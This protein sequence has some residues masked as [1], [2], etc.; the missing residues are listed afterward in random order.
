MESEAKVTATKTDKVGHTWRKAVDVTIKATL[1]GGNGLPRAQPRRGSRLHFTKDGDFLAFE[2]VVEDTLRTRRMRLCDRCLMPNHWHFVVW[3]Q[4][5]GDLSA[6]MQQVTETHVKRW[7]EHRH[8]IGYGHLYQG[9]TSVSQWKLKTR[10][11]MSLATW[12]GTP[13]VQTSW[14]ERN[15]GDGQVCAVWSME[16]QRF[17][18]SRRGRF[19]ALPIGCNLADP[20][21]LQVLKKCRVSGRRHFCHPTSFQGRGCENGRSTEDPASGS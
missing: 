19:L 5:D 10:S 16:A 20:T 11:I 12:R 3:P 2:R 1:S 7:K 9:H 17:P 14:T 4:R 8:E 21:G 6:F 18:S 15:P 13:C